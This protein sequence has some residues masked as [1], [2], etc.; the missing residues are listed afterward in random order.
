MILGILLGL[1]ILALILLGVS[2]FYS[3]Y[4]TSNVL[5]VL[6]L[7]CLVGTVIMFIVRMFYWIFKSSKD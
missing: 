4:D 5:C 6:G 3:D 1:F 2:S 7:V